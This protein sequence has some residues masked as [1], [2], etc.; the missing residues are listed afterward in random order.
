MHVLNDSCISRHTTLKACLF[1][2]HKDFDCR[3]GG[4]QKEWRQVLGVCFKAQQ[5]RRP[6]DL[7]Q[8]TANEERTVQPA[9]NLLSNSATFTLKRN[10]Y[11]VVTVRQLQRPKAYHDVYIQSDYSR[12]V[13]FFSYR[14]VF[15]VHSKNTN[16]DVGGQISMAELIQRRTDLSMSGPPA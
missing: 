6:F 14:E 8:F 4:A 10:S 12:R 2:E 15:K 3:G 5:S 16:S 13:A 7:V 9:A 1:G 11:Y